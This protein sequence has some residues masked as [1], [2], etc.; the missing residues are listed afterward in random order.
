MY[1]NNWSLRFELIKRAVCYSILRGRFFLNQWS[2][3]FC[4]YTRSL[5]CR[6]W[7]FYYKIRDRLY[8]IT[9]LVDPSDIVIFFF[10]NFGT[11]CSSATGDGVKGKSGHK[12]PP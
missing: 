9:G 2:L 4:G 3:R 7:F 12:P 11:L 5:T 6:V 10:Q 1:V 8:D